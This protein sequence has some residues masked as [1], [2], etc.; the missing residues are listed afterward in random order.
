MNKEL[1]KAIEAQDFGTAYAICAEAYEKA[2]RVFNPMGFE[3]CL[4]EAKIAS[5]GDTVVSF[6]GKNNL[7]VTY[8]F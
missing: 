3:P 7:G 2:G 6:S 1:E 4:V 5:D 8:Y